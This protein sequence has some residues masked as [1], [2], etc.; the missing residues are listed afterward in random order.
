[1]KHFESF[2]A[3]LFNEF[4]T[5]RKDM[6]YVVKHSR[7]HLFI[8]DRYLLDKGAVWDSLT[9]SFFLQMRADLPMEPVSINAVLLT[10]R[11]FFKFLLRRGHL[12]K[13]PVQD[14]P[15]LKENI[16]VP[17]V[18]SPEQTDR[19]ITACSNRIRRTKRFF[20]TDFAIYLALLLLARCG[21]RISEPLRLLRHHYR[22]DESTIY[23][24]KT[25]FKKDRLLPIPM[26][27]ADEINNYLSVRERLTPDD[28]NTYLL[29][30]KNQS[31]LLAYQIR[32]AFH[33]AV[34]DIGLNQ[35][36][37]V[38]GN[39]NFL[40]PS[41][42]SLR[43]SFA[44]NTLRAII[45]RGESAQA[46][47]PVLSAYLGHKKYHYSAVYLKVADAQSRND[48]LDFTTWQEWKKI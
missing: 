22:R 44:I 48:L 40:Q 16:T 2:L 31:P 11:V 29:A 30:N 38:V 35:N 6:G 23:I 24:E 25:K 28:K 14:V 8:F 19:L 5:Y 32:Y 33:Q 10:L 47:L 15:L 36:R 17:F 39:M 1:M 9:P 45:E 12:E 20:L 18:F 7:S 4:L 41:P 34:R 13:S 21:L 27:V 3:N 37:R 42:H 46:S 43:H 26:A